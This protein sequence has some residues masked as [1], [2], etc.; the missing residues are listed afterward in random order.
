[1]TPAASSTS[2]VAVIGPNPAEDRILEVPGFSSDGVFRSRRSLHGAGGKPL[3][4][5]R[6][7]SRLGIHP[8]LVLPLGPNLPVRNSVKTACRDLGI[9]LRAIPISGDTRTCT[10]IV[11]PESGRTAVI[12]EPGPELTQREVSAYEEAAI[13]AV[14]SH[15]F[16]IGSGSLPHGLGP[17]F[18][19][20]LAAAAGRVGTRFILDSSAG[21]LTRALDSRPWAIKVNADEIREVS[22][23][24]DLIA[25]A[26]WVRKYGVDH[27]VVTQG[28]DGAIYLGSE[29][30]F[31]VSSPVVERV[32]TVGAGDAFS[33]GLLYGLATRGSWLA[34]LPMAAATSGL[35]ISRFE[36]DIGP[37]QD[38][39]ALA[40]Q[41]EL[42][43]LEHP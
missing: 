43:P 26:E 37:G 12:N 38:L 3:N 17:G 6:V 33:A 11:D 15:S 5:A 28:S 8:L 35:W 25:S 29:G 19:G 14:T 13:A 16:A 10:V 24:S 23:R 36:P 22:A 18:Y 20:H 4:V 9:N 27:V 40:S 31:N 7:L 34:A 32:N 41:I 2:N 21:A 39:E 42:E 30:A 1:M